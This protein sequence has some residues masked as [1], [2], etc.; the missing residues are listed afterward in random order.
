M[1]ECDV[2]G[3]DDAVCPRTNDSLLSDMH[4]NQQQRNFGSTLLGKAMHCGQGDEC[5][6]I[7]TQTLRLHR[8]IHIFNTPCP[9]TLCDSTLSIRELHDD[10]VA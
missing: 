3:G 9:S 7:S 1:I 10:L 2:V 4:A 6:K 5:H 8:S